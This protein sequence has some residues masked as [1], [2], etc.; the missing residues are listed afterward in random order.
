MTRLCLA[1]SAG[2]TLLLCGCGGEEPIAQYKVAKPRDNKASAASMSIP[3]PTSG[4][5]AEQAWFV[6][7]LGPVE[8][9][10]SNIE[11]FVRLLGSMDFSGADPLIDL[12]SGWRQL[13]GDN[14]R[15]ATLVYDRA[16]PPLEV[17]VSTLPF[18][19]TQRE[20]FTLANL[21]RWRGQLGLQTWDASS[22]REIGEATQ[23]LVSLDSGHHH[24]E[25]VRLV[26]MAEG[27]EAMMMA[28]V[29][30][31]IE[32]DASAM[33]S[34]PE[35]SAPFDYE[36]PEGWEVAAGSPI[37]IASFSCPGEAG[38]LDISVT[39]FP[40]GGDL[41]P[42]INRW[43]GQVMLKE[44]TEDELSTVM[45]PLEVSGV[46]SYFA[47]IV[48]EEQGILVAAVPDGDAQWFFKAQG[49][50]ATIEAEGEH[51]QEFLRSIKL[52]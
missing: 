36:L 38:P 24:L 41:L 27:K 2:L 42:N 1:L 14:F 4:D 9:V 37:R 8:Q 12:P 31:P 25:V 34:A 5:G 21:N 50:V 44:I 22:W 29:F 10:A 23:E 16:E 32:K 33:A 11:P 43:R 28:A 30:L 13:P 17:S 7:A 3:R 47:E 52:K 40:G 26:G 20:S 48:G 19:A 35:S 18:D 46:E 39:R 15:F 51:F 45:K 49:P 6:K